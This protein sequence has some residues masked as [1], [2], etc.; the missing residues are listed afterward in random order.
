[1]QALFHYYSENAGACAITSIRG[2]AMGSAAAHL[3]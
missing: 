2:P 1:L 3:S